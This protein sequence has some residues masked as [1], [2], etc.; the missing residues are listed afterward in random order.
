MKTAATLCVVLFAAAAAKADDKPAPLDPAKLVGSW[1]YVA[2]TRAGEKVDKER[3]TGPV[4][5]TKETF[6]L[7]GSEP[8]FVIG[9][10]VDAKASPATI[11]MSIKDGPVK[12]GKALGII[13]VNG[14][15]LT[16]CYDPS[17][18]KRPAKFESTKD[19]GAFL[20]VLKRVK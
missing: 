9:Y 16:L 13:A 2:G 11:D 3:M 4:V 1:T 18:Q 17:G 12:E 15:E 10:T 19:N 20:F 8:K 14:D 7:P 5:V 6:T